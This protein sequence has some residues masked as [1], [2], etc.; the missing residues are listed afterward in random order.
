MCYREGCNGDTNHQHNPLGAPLNVCAEHFDEVF[1]ALNASLQNKITA[2]Q[3]RDYAKIWII[4][5]DKSFMDEGLQYL[6][7]QMVTFRDKHK[8]CDEIKIDE[9]PHLHWILKRYEEKHGF[10]YVDAILTGILEAEHFLGNL[11][12]AY[13]SC[14]FGADADHGAFTHRLQWFVV[15]YA[16]CGKQPHTAIQV[17]QW[18]TPVVDLYKMLGEAKTR[19]RIDGLPIKSG[20]KIGAPTLWPAL[21]DRAG[22]GPTAGLYNMPD[23]LHWDIRNDGL[24]GGVLQTAICDIQR[25]VI[26]RRIR[27]LNGLQMVGCMELPRRLQGEQLSQKIRDR[28]DIIERAVKGEN[29]ARNLKYKPLGQGEF[30]IASEAPVDFLCAGKGSFAQKVGMTAVLNYAEQLIR[31][32][33]WKWGGPNFLVRKNVRTADSFAL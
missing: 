19:V 18:K 32:G 7:N 30:Q 20:A 4:M 33:R 3:I 26:G 23:R 6:G 5:M 14:D 12:D 8:D 25:E 2:D 21:L 31:G 16:A 27:V 28:P 22:K 13:P 24:G 10:N 9:L 29:I 1:N 17:A 15:M 11:T